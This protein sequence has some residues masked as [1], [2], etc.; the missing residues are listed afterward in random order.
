[1]SAARESEIGI[2]LNL[3]TPRP[4]T[5]AA[6]DR[7]AVEIFMDER[8]R[9]FTGPLTGRGYPERLYETFPHVARP[10]IQPGD[11]ETIAR[12]GTYLGLNYYD[13]QSVQHDA[14]SGGPGWRT[15]AS[16]T[17]QTDMGWPI[18][19]GG[20]ERHVAWVRDTVGNIPLV[21]A[22][23]GIAVADD[24]HSVADDWR[25]IRFIEEHLQ[26]L[27]RAIEAGANVTG[28]YYWSLMDNFEWALGLSKRF[29]LIHVDYTTFKRTPRRSYY[30][31]R[32][33]IANGPLIGRDAMRIVE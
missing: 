33:R 23:N 14:R 4:A 26:A 6:A 15:T 11:M 28:Y 1:V 29:G 2:V 13:E 27:E 12:I 19:P 10:E 9:L 25:R 24:A 8:N 20:L 17:P 7:E 16:W 22:E 18:V 3:H 30:Y 5:R 21:I 32:D 31:Y